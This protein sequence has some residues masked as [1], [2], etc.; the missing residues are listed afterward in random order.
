MKAEPE[1]RMENDRRTYGIAGMLILGIGIPAVVIA[2]LH[3]FFSGRPFVHPPLHAFMEAL[4]VLAASSLAFLLIFLRKVDRDHALHIWIACGLLAMGILDGLHS[5]QPVG[6][7]FVWLRCASTLFG[8]CLFSLVWLPQS[9]SRMRPVDALPLAT[10]AVA[11]LFGLVIVARPDLLPAVFDDD[12]YSVTAKTVTATGGILFVV[13]AIRFVGRYRAAG[14]FDDFLFASLCLLMGMAGLSFPLSFVWFADWW[15][16]HLL[17][18]V[19][20]L[21]IGSYI[22]FVFQQTLAELKELN[23]TL[24]QR[25]M[26]RTAQLAG[27]V[28]ERKQTE[29]AL[30]KSETRYRRLVDSVTGYIYSVKV[31]DGRPVRTSHSSGCVAVTGYTPEEYASDPELWIR[32]VHD[33]DRQAVLVQADLVLS[34]KE[35]PLLE[36]RIVR[37]DGRLCWVKNMIVPHFDGGGRLVA[38]DGLISDITERKLAEEETRTY[39]AELLT[40][41][42]VVTACSG[43]HDFREVLG[44]ILVETMGIVGLEE[45]CLCVLNNDGSLN[46]I[47]RQRASE[48][49]TFDHCTDGGIS[50]CFYRACAG[51]LQPIILRD[52]ESVLRVAGDRALHGEAVC[53]HAAFPLVTGKRTCAGVL[54][55]YSQTEA[56]PADR[57]IRLVETIAAHVALLI[58]NA[59]LYEETLFH[60]ATLEGKVAER[61]LELKEANLKLQEIDR[62]KSLFIASMS[63]EL[64]T[65]LNSVIG[66]TSIILDEWIGPLNNE[67]KENLVIVLKAGQHLLALINDV[68]DVSKIEAGQMEVQRESFDLHDVVDEAV[69]TMGKE[70]H[71]KGLVLRVENVNR[72]MLNADR[73]RLLQCILNLLSN[74]AKYT[75]KGTISVHVKVIAGDNLSRP[76]VGL[77]SVEIVVEDTGIGMG[78]EDL[79]RIFDP[80]AR[81]DSRLR[82][83]VPGTGL[84]LYLTRKLVTEVLKGE[85]RCVSRQGSGSTFTMLI[86]V[87][88]EG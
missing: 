55:L 34:G 30:K 82:S 27:E 69:T 66:F 32:M 12:G 10:A 87:D 72:V 86:P 31:E 33:E 9:V 53:F 78:S 73:R 38:Y 26:D 76:V 61:T 44:R 3:F 83:R 48:M 4:G 11:V 5:I 57:S 88:G 37:K 50:D 45:G 68:I 63:H 56:K 52:R 24:E 75:E 54:C 70:I 15:F 77:E 35:V 40:I 65:P 42:R 81:L 19:A 74:A 84:G 49:V 62:I 36:H 28:A 71:D 41:N 46:C 43:L 51:D 8:G 79:A 25:V 21:H 13:A 80:F 59:R 22:F 1:N 64:R 60:A 47:A 7:S 23:E 16:W 58:E 39:N 20:F 18:L 2:V 17:R 67:Q 29:V 14:C 85:I 6:P